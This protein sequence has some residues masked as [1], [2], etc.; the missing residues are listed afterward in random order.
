MYSMSIAI[1]ARPAR[2]TQMKRGLVKEREKLFSRLPDLNAAIKEA[3][4]DH[5][6]SEKLTLA[7]SLFYLRSG[8]PD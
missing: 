8:M 7:T 2:T 4:P 6:K 1:K 3:K 5:P